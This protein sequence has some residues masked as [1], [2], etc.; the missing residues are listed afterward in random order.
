MGRGIWVQVP[1]PK[2]RIPE[3]V[4]EALRERLE[5]HARTEWA[6]RCRSVL[7]RFRG[8]FAYVDAV[9]D[10]P[11]FAVGPDGAGQIAEEPVQLCRLGYLGGPDRWAF[12]F[13]TYAHMRYEPSVV[14]SGS[15]VAT[16]EEAFDCAAQVHL[17]R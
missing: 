12:A 15:F 6:R 1:R 8:P 7:V 3:R 2:G 9:P 14:W 4:R 5:A 10:E 17:A 16:P 11:P 13:F